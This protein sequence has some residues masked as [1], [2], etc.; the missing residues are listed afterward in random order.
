MF[1][2]SNFGFWTILVPISKRGTKSGWSHYL[3]LPFVTFSVLL[4]VRKLDGLPFA[5]FRYLWGLRT[6]LSAELKA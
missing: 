1:F 2:S 3:F 5:T 6:S 4:K